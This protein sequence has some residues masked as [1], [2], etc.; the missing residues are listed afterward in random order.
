[1]DS[2]Y[3]IMVNSVL[4]ILKHEYVIF[5]DDCLISEFIDRYFNKKEEEIQKCKTDKEKVLIV[6]QRR[7]FLEKLFHSACIFG[8]HLPIIQYLVQNYGKMIDIA[9]GYELACICEHEHIIVYLLHYKRSNKSI[10]T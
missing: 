8:S 6:L 1:M 5:K 9:K 2:D 7:Y 4:K 3:R 10:I